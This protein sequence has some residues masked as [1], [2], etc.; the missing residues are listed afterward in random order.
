MSNKENE[1]DFEDESVEEPQIYSVSKDLKQRK[2]SRREFIEVMTL[3]STAVAITACGESEKEPSGTSN[4]NSGSN[5][6]FTSDPTNTSV[7]EPDPTKTSTAQPTATQTATPTETPEP[8]VKVIQDSVNFRTGPGTNYYVVRVLSYGEPLIL[9]GRLSDNSWFF[10]KTLTGEEGWIKATLLDLGGYPVDNLP[11]KTPPPTPIPPE[12]TDV[13]GT[14]GNV[15]PGET[16]IEYTKVDS[17][18]RTITYTLPCGSPI[19]AGAVCTCNCVT[20]PAAGCSCDGYVSCTCDAVT[21][22][23]WYPN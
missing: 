9:L 22:H 20:V 15:E 1:N 10:A 4:G 23:Y 14:E 16:G 3:A 7:S 2:Y 17:S 11:L 21:S 13:P 18:G 6:N 8:E 5:G 12:P 19:P